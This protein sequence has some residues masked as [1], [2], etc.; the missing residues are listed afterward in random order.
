MLTNYKH[1]FRILTLRIYCKG[2]KNAFTLFLFRTIILLFVILFLAC[3]SI[4]ISK[5]AIRTVTG[6]I[7]KVSDGDTAH[8]TA[9]EQT[10]QKS[11]YTV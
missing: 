9:P 5:A 11:G 7:T 4:P 10:K 2:R 3:T 8:L 6:T 1:K